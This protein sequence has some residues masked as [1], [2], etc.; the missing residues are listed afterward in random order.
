[1]VTFYSFKNGQIFTGLTVIEYLLA[2]E[3]PGD[4]V[5]RSFRCSHKVNLPCSRKMKL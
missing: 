4:G 2:D 1:M 5:W 3:G